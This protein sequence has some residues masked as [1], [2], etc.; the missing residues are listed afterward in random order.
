MFKTLPLRITF[1]IQ[2]ALNAAA[3]VKYRKGATEGYA[4]SYLQPDD[5]TFAAWGIIY[6]LLT[7]LVF[8]QAR[9]FD[10]TTLHALSSAFLLNG[11][12]LIANG[13]AV[14]DHLSY[15]LAVVVLLVYVSMLATAYDGAGVNYH[16]RTSCW[17]QKLGGFAPLSVNLA[18]VA[19]AAVLNVTNT[20]ADMRQD[21]SKHENRTKI[22][23]PDWTIAMIG[24][25]ALKSMQLSFTRSDVFYAMGCA[26]AYLGVA[27]NQGGDKVRSLSP[28]RS[29]LSGD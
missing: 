26:W 24:L 23:S 8:F 3:F 19:L 29:P 27:R 12:W 22:G 9:R 17:S 6:A 2:I 20:L 28:F 14:Y 11:F 4:Y 18:W 21:F 5:A 7:M 13:A 25:T 10:R 1:L 16:S 15:W